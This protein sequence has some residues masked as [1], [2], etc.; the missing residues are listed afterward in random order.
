[1]TKAI[2]ATCVAGVVT[3]SG[4][5]VPSATK[6]SEGVGQSSGV[7]LLDGETAN[8]IAN[9][10]PDLKT[11]IEKLVDIT[12]KIVT[13]FT[14]IGAGMTGATTAPPGTLATDTASITAIAV[15]LT[16]LKA[17]LK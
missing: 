2:A 15:E 10:T 6:L 5:P 12:N 11:T 4:V 1:M 8:Y 13:L 9:T 14:A 7:L 17:M 16:A 3:A